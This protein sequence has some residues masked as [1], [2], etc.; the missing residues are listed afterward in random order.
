[1]M[2]P[3]VFA[4]TCQA[5]ADCSAEMFNEITFTEARSEFSPLDKIYVLIFCRQVSAGN[6]S[7]HVNWV[8]EQRGVVRSDKTVIEVAEPSDQTIYFWLNLLRRGPLASMLAGNEFYE[9]HYGIWVVE[10][11][12]DDQ[13]VTAT[14][15]TIRE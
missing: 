14:E 1:M 15:F 10:G 8:H 5:Q 12:L 4:G 7:I 11:Y 6:H 13:Q 3:A 9:D 2:L